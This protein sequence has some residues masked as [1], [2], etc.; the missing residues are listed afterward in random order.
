MKHIISL[1]TL[2]AFFIAIVACQ[3]T[4]PSPTEYESNPMTERI[5]Q[6]IIDDSKRPNNL[7][8]AIPITQKRAFFYD[9]YYETGFK[10]YRQEHELMRLVDSLLTN[11]PNRSHIYP[12]IMQ[13]KTP[14]S[15]DMT[16]Y[17][18]LHKMADKYSIGFNQFTELLWI[19][20]YFWRQINNS[21]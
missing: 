7:D 14:Y 12:D 11:D 15:I 1:I 19:Y 10:I 8:S 2:C 21:T 6:E 9:R 20:S 13:G 17:E 16:K 4:R 5:I 18:M 3:N